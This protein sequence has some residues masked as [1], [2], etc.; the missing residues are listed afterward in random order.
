LKENALNY[1]DAGTLDSGILIHV[2]HV[3]LCVA[4]D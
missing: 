1:V 3:V 4:C 2:Q